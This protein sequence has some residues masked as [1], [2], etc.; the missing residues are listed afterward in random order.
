MQRALRYSK[1]DY[2]YKDWV[3]TMPVYTIKLGDFNQEK[4][5][6]SYFKHI[7]DA[8]KSV[9]MDEDKAYKQVIQLLE[10]HIFKILDKVMVPYVYEGKDEVKFEGFFPALDKCVQ[11]SVRIWNIENPSKPIEVRLSLAGDV[12]QSL[13]ALVYKQ[14]HAELESKNITLLSAEAQDERPRAGEYANKD[15]QGVRSIGEFMQVN[16]LTPEFS[17]I[18]LLLIQ[19]Y[20]PLHNLL[21]FGIDSKLDVWYEIKGIS[22]GGEYISDFKS[23]VNI[24]QIITNFIS[25]AEGKL[26]LLNKEEIK[27][28]LIPS[29]N[30]QERG[31]QPELSGATINMLSVVF[32][33]TYNSNGKFKVKLIQPEP[34]RIENLNIL[35]EFIDGFYS[36]L[37]GATPALQRQT[38]L[39]LSAMFVIPFLK[40]KDTA[41]IQQQLDVLDIDTLDEDAKAQIQ[42]VIRGSYFNAANN[43]AYR[44]VGGLLQKLI[45]NNNTT[46]FVFRDTIGPNRKV[47]NQNGEQVESLLTTKDVFFEQYCH[48]NG[49]DYVVYHGTSNAQSMLSIIRSGFYMSGYGQGVDLGGSALYALCNNEVPYGNYTIPLILLNNRNMRI[50]DLEKLCKNAPL[51]NEAL[52]EEAKKEGYYDLNS[53]LYSKYHVDILFS[54]ELVMVQNANVFYVPELNMILDEMEAEIL[55][56]LANIPALGATKI[57]HSI[58]CLFELQGRLNPAKQKHLLE[59]IISKIM[60]T[61]NSDA[62]GLQICEFDKLITDILQHTYDYD[63]LI[64]KYNIWLMK[65]VSLKLETILNEPSSMNFMS[66]LYDCLLVVDRGLSDEFG[67]EKIEEINAEF[68]R[69]R[70]KVNLTQLDCWAKNCWLKLDRTK[71]TFIYELIF[72][73]FSIQSELSDKEGDVVNLLKKL[74]FDHKL[75]G[76]SYFRPLTV[77]FVTELFNAI[78]IKNEECKN[79]GILAF[80]ESINPT[81]GSPLAGILLY[82]FINKIYDAALNSDA[83]CLRDILKKDEW[84]SFDLEKVINELRVLNP[85]NLPKEAIIDLEVKL[86]LLRNT[87]QRSVILSK[88]PAILYSLKSSQKAKP[89]KGGGATFNE[90]STSD[91]RFYKYQWKKQL[92][93]VT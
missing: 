15:T 90:P 18:R 44:D 23:K 31:E 20:N 39:G 19:K 63:L 26:T 46:I 80:L 60:S 47:N 81:D 22:K 71:M 91:A 78:A 27:K 40:I 28:S 4:E 93:T 45:K 88:P 72:K 54:K 84:N 82:N 55:P 13:L 73:T 24:P 57:A 61:C 56:A 25:S 86:Q 7:I 33:T 85:A 64:T 1:L 52:K 92:H 53:L 17:M 51:L 34:Q 77:T 66:E 69:K 36:Y 70:I 89:V 48:K 8:L 74:S 38:I 2:N 59:K 32:S 42:K 29:L 30:V 6:P 12:V 65:L 41:I 83:N 37:V 75:L 58:N 3:V 10:K 14:L 79:A 87:E 11:K 35:R 62:S 76:S 16:A 9:G 5:F 68:E 67:V 49:N 50:L 21:V 43:R